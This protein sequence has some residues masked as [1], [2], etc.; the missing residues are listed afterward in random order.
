MKKGIEHGIPLSKHVVKLL[1]ELKKIS[2]ESEY[3]F[4]SRDS[5]NKPISK[6]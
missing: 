4:P 3:L 1:M 5:I 6:L 2:P